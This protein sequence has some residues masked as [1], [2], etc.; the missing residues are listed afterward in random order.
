MRNIHAVFQV[1][2]FEKPHKYCVFMGLTHK[3]AAKT[4]AF[5]EARMFIFAP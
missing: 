4:A 5:I 2:L 1:F 3:K